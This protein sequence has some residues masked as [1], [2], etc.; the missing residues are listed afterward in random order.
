[1]AHTAVF[2]SYAFIWDE[3]QTISPRKKTGQQLKCKSSLYMKN[4][5]KKTLYKNVK[6]FKK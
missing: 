2:I 3:T 4:Q 6:E 5:K 1:M